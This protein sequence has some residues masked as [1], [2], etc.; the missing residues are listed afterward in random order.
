MVQGV[1]VKAIQDELISMMDL[2]S[3]IYMRKIESGSGKM[4]AVGNM[5]R[6]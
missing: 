6:R 4:K 3:G 1:L 5:S 2:E